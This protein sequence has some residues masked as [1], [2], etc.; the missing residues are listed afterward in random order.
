MANP[1]FNVDKVDK[2]KLKDDP[3]YPFALPK[4]DNANYLWIQIFYSTLNEKGRA[5]FVMANSAGDARG[6]ELEIRKMMLEDRAVDVMISVGPNFFYT[7]TLPCTLW[8]LDRG[9]K[10]TEALQ[11]EHPAK[12]DAVT[13][14]KELQKLEAIVE[15]LTDK[16]GK[17]PTKAESK[18]K[19]LRNGP[20]AT[21]A[22]RELVGRILT[23]MTDRVKGQ[24]END[25][26][27][28]WAELLEDFFARKHPSQL[29]FLEIDKR[30]I[31]AL[32]K[33]N[34]AAKA[35]HKEA[36]GYE[37]GFKAERRPVRNVE[38]L[39]DETC[40]IRDK[41]G[42]VFRMSQLGFVRSDGTPTYAD[43]NPVWTP[44][45]D[46]KERIRRKAMEAGDNMQAQFV[47]K[48]TG[49]LAAIVEA[50]ANLHGEPKIVNVRYNK[51]TIE[52]NVKFSFKD[53][54]HFTVRNKIVSKRSYHS[55][56]FHQHPTTFHDAVLPNGEGIP[57]QPSEQQMKSVF[58][59]KRSIRH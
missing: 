59:K 48:N 56:G 53:G 38:S 17:A 5:G 35:K 34:E 47:A 4:A 57:G 16:I 19:E 32:R 22:A 43:L 3:R 1:P 25:L 40:V 15:Y 14:L 46:W 23:R 26:E 36:T 31:E 18:A 9:K 6:S 20:P 21:K 37:F 54:S 39:L 8:F 2:E 28:G 55:G 13:V 12:H 30:S 24:Y 58:V 45:R 7:V 29:K 10:K 42:E 50:K 44:H 52:G 11:S 27:D 33:R 49:K 41:G 51:G